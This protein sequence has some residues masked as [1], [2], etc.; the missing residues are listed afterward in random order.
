MVKFQ[1]FWKPTS[2]QVLL[3]DQLLLVLQQAGETGVGHGQLHKLLHA[4]CEGAVDGKNADLVLIIQHHGR[5]IGHLITA[6][7]GCTDKV[8]VRASPTM[9]SLMPSSRRLSTL[10]L[11]SVARTS[12][13]ALA[14]SVAITWPTFP[15]A[16]VTS[17]IMV[18]LSKC[19]SE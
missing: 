5:H 6:A 13:P 1:L 8:L 2:F 7:H 17:T 4:L 11:M 16:L 18:L 19:D 3:D 14:S 10:G 12:K 9:T 15:I